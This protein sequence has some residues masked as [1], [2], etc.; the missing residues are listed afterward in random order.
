[1]ARLNA[2]FWNRNKFKLSGLVLLLPVYFLYRSL[3]P[4]FPAAMAA[5]TVGEFSVIPTPLDDAQPYQHDGEYI[6]DFMVTFKQGDLAHI[7]QGYMNI[8][9]TALP[10]SQ[11][12]QGELGI[13]H[14]SRYGQHVHALASDHIDDGARLWL[15][16]ETWQGKIL[17]TSWPLPTEWLAH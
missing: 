2:N 13:L 17:V 11:M 4:S 1:M 7:R 9:T 8:G 14:G 15:T 5:A 3:H 6:K 10:L 16:L 12:Q